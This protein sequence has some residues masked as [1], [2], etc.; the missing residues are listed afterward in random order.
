MNKF[1]NLIWIFVICILVVSAAFTGY[2]LAFRNLIFPKVSVAGIGVGGMDKIT[3]L[4]LVSKY[5]STNPNNVILRINEK[6][7]NK[8]DEIKVERDF[9]WAI[10]QAYSVGR[11]GNILTQVSEQLRTLYSSRSISVPISYEGDDL[12]VYVDQLATDFNQK[13]VWPKL[14]IEKDKI[15]AVSGKD[16]LEIDKLQLTSKIVESWSL[17]DK[18]IIDVP[19][20]VVSAKEN[21]ELVDRA[22]ASINE[23][24]GRR[25]TLKHEGFETSLSQDEM[26]ALYGLTREVVNKDQFGNLLARIQPL[27]ETE[28]RDA[29]FRFEE[30]KVLE[31]KPEVVGR[32]ID[33]PA[34]N[35]KLG[36]ALVTA[37]SEILEIPVIFSYPKIKAGDINNLGIKELI[38][39]G[40][41]LFSH[42]IPGRV[43]NVNLAASRI[44]STIVAPGEEFSFNDAVGDIS[45]ASGYQS[46]YIIS[47][48]K[49]V[50][51]DGGGVC[52]VSTTV[53]R[54]ALNAGLTITERKAHAYR[55]GYYEQD[56][57]PG[58]DATVYNPTADLKFLN[59]TG[60]HILI[61][62]K[63]DTKNMN[64]SVQIYG[65]KD[66]RVA[67]ISVPKISSQTPPPA[68]LYVDD[69]TLP[70]GQMKQIDWSAWGAKVSFNY[71]V[72]KGTET[73][74]EKTF[75]SNYQ[76][77][78]AVY[79]KGTKI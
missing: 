49:T 43:F 71:K 79:L 30:E 29:V 74:F 33:V 9:N 38:G 50:L 39:E 53:F 34:F 42:S 31:F 73:L 16:G 63:V 8:L 41:S 40:K 47:G 46:A 15:M 10:E 4:K 44:N 76:P 2:R 3:A 52:Q 22:I 19:T 45:K 7:I 54:A 27:V 72:T 55:V 20:G 28:S 60:N 77:W 64:M 35:E 37:N 18:Q 23:W 48:G 67:S 56:S 36:E 11:N 57:K 69:P 26:V 13:P 78:R 68:T 65:T 6:E 66:G 51:G 59:D 24:G 75:Y 1:K 12:E 25:L 5:F 70:L 14:V 61:Q 32:V 58:I 62:T 17:P 21:K